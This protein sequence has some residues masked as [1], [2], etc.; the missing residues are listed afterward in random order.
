MLWA[1]LMMVGWGPLA[2]PPALLAQAPRPELGLIRSWAAHVDLDPDRG[3]VEQAVLHV[4]RKRY[5]TVYRVKNQ[6]REVDFSEQAYDGAGLVPRVGGAR[7]RAENLALEL[8]ERGGTP[9]IVELR[10]PVTTLYVQT[11]TGALQALDAHT[12]QSRWTVQIGRPYFPSVAPAANDEV[13]AVIAGTSL[14]LLEA[15]TGN[16]LYQ[17]QSAG[18]PTGGLAI[19]ER[20]VYMPAASG[21][22]EAYDLTDRDGRTP[23]RFASEG[24]VR[25][26]PL[27]IGESL[28]WGSEAGAVFSVDVLHSRVNF[29]AEVVAPIAGSLVP[30]GANLFVVATE[31]GLVHA[32]DRRS[33]GLVW[34]Q[35]VGDQIDHPV[36]VDG[37]VYVPTRRSGAFAFDGETGQQLWQVDGIDRLLALSPTRLYGLDG[38]NLLSAVDR[39]QGTVTATSRAKHIDLAMTN[40]L[41]DRIYLGSRRGN[42]VCL[43]EP[44]AA[45]P[46]VRLPD[47]GP[48]PPA[49]GSPA[50]TSS[51]ASPSDRLPPRAPG[52]RQD[53]DEPAEDPSIDDMPPDAGADDDPFG[54]GDGGD[55][56]AE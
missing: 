18:V 45:W 26:A 19:D 24:V 49:P 47:L 34:R 4:S 35:S 51:S 46:H 17:R 30:L 6:G 43:R 44:D 14:T 28:L 13:V 27:P 55:P 10:V 21:M 54:T 42:L 25:H 39:Q 48:T 8:T 23:W 33:G 31:D 11:N 41:T 5:F 40:S 53:G 38:D 7:Q 56:F 37:V 3:R 2:L 52:E 16:A 22:V 15:E 32:F 12:G 29:T 1:S 36:L 9:E 50:D 20:F